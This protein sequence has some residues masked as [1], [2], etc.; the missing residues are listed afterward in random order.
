MIRRG[1]CNCEGCWRCQR[2]GRASNSAVGSTVVVV[3]DVVVTSGVMVVVDAGTVVVVV[4]D[5]AS[6]DGSGDSA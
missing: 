5:V 6:A 3:V 4:G 2:P 1:P